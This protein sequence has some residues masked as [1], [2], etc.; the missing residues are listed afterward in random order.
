MRKIRQREER[1]NK[2]IMIRIKIGGIC[3]LTILIITLN[4]NDLNTPFKGQRLSGR[5]KATS[6]YMLPDEYIL[7]RNTKIS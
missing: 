3:N 2:N 7:N 5:M 6:N 1:E 4:I